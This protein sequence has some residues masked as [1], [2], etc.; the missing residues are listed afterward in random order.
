MI[1]YLTAGES[2]GPALAGIIDGVP[3]GL[4]LDVEAIDAALQR[5]Q[6]GHG[7]GARMKIERDAV[8]F[9]AGLRGGVTLGSP[10]AVLLRNR[11]YDNV[12][13]LMDPL[14]GAG[15]A[16]TRP[17][18]GHADYAGALKYRHRDLRNVLERA[19]ARETAMRVALGEIAR[20]YLRVFEITVYGFVFQ[21]GDVTADVTSEDADSLKETDSPVRCPDAEASARMVARIDRARSDGDTLGGAFEIR[22]TGM[23]VGI[24]GNRQPHDRLDAR[25]AAAMMG[26]QTV[27]AVEVGEGITS[28]GF[29]G[30]RSHDTFEAGDGGVLRGSNRAGGIEGGMSNGQDLVVRVRVKPIATLMKPLASVDLTT[31]AAAPATIVRSDVCAVPAASIIAE[32]MLCLALADACAEK[33]GGDSVAEAREHFEASQAGAASVFDRDASR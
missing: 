14:T 28:G 20:Q 31:G 21:I 22:A 24:G 6:G 2:H 30:S 15:P 10:I 12:R 1:R 19:S 5:R 33:Y 27:K 29:V 32:A 16:I 8:E 3:A 9:V 23:P 25:V 18:P 7:R 26:I 13:A 4:R 17:R 11:D